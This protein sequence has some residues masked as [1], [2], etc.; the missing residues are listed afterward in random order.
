MAQ[1]QKSQF[2]K[3]SNEETEVVIRSIKDNIIKANDRR[4]VLRS[5]LQE[6]ELIVRNL[7]TG[8][9]QQ[10]KTMSIM[11]NAL[12]QLVSKDEVSNFRKKHNIPL[13]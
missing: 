3:Y 8:V 5:D 12:E 6:A 13:M 10:E 9:R 4:K 11:F 2:T 1:E 7:D